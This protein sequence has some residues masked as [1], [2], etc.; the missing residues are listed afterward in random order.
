MVIF[1]LWLNSLFKLYDEKNTY[2]ENPGLLFEIFIL[3]RLGIREVIDLDAMLIDFIQ[4]LE[5]IKK[6]I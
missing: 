3:I 5:P 4:N 2:L 6:S 1:L